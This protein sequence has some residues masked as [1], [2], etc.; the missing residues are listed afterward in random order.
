MSFLYEIVCSCVNVITP[1]PCTQVSTV[2]TAKPS[3][4]VSTVPTARPSTQVSTVTSA[5]PSISV[6]KAEDVSTTSPPAVT[7]STNDVGKGNVGKRGQTVY[8]I[9]IITDQNVC[10]CCLNVICEYLKE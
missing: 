8:S 10:H 1:V 4:Q 9:V 7:T 5:G 6:S 2:P 3:T